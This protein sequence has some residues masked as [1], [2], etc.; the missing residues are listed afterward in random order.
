[1]LS[2]VLEKQGQVWDHHY[3][4]GCGW[5]EPDAA[6]AKKRSMRRAASCHMPRMLQT[7]VE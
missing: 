3:S 6:G 4:L 5:Q 1:M 7:A 2:S